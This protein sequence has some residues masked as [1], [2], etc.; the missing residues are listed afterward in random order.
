MKELLMILGAIALV[1]LFPFLFFWLGW[2]GGWITMLTIGEPLTRGLNTLFNTAYFTKEMIPIC[3]A[4]LGWIGGY[5]KARTITIDK[6]K[7]K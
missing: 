7:N 2:F 4:T 3:A 1:V 5:F 6:N